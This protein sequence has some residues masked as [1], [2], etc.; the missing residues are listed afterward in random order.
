MAL[1]LGTNAGFVTVAPTDDPAESGFTID[2]STWASKDTSPS[3]DNKITE[4]GWYCDNS[5]QE[6]NFEV[7]IYTDDSDK[8]DIVVGS[9][10]QT[11][12]KGT[13]AGWKRVTGL[14]IPI[15]ASTIYW[16]A[17]ELDNTIPG[18]DAD[19][20]LSGG[21]LDVKNAVELT[22]PWGT[23]NTSLDWLPAIYAVIETEPPP[24]TPTPT[25]SI[26]GAGSSIKH[27][28]KRFPEL[29]NNQMQLYYFQ[30]PHKQAP[31][32]FVGRVTKVTDGDTIRV[33]A[34][35][36]DFDFPVRMSELA[37]PELNE[38]GGKESQSWLEDQIL[39]EE[40][41]IYLTPQRVEKW[42]RLLAAV[43]FQG[44]NMSKLSIMNGQAVSWED[45][46]Q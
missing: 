41:E 32:R 9:L 15:S 24:P 25:E 31:E 5:T 46:A 16:I 10:S 42:G 29:T 14:N 2:N 17:V 27:D 21:R 36:R 1:V 28:F 23:T 20:K 18:T 40:V 6:A 11:N 19:L 43:M 7:G 33:S 44:M 4:I 30:S 12:A 26:D 35:F 3:G 37:A 38:S 34:D 45:R 13:D 22:D 39:G 8:P